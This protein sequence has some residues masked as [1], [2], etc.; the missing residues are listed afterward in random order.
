M[1]KGLEKA[2]GFISKT[3]IRL[4]TSVNKEA[5]V[6]LENMK[7]TYFKFYLSFSGFNFSHH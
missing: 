3:I 5:I 1:D 6:L 7:S 4:Q 2:A